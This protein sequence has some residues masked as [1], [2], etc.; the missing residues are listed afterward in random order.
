MKE[1]LKAFFSFT[2]KRQQTKPNVSLFI[3]ETTGKINNDALVIK[4]VLRKQC[5][6]IYKSV[7]LHQSMTK[8]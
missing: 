7:L 6:Y 5:I 4:Y 2:G 3:D 1:N 8:L